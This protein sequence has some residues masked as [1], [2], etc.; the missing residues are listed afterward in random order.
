[1]ANRYEL[2]L[3]QRPAVYDLGL[4]GKRTHVFELAL[5]GGKSVRS[6]VF[7][8][9]IPF[10]ESFEVN[11]GVLIAGGV[12]SL[13]ALKTITAGASIELVEQVGDFLKI[14][15]VT[16]DAG[17]EIGAH[18][19]ASLQKTAPIMDAGVVAAVEKLRGLAVSMTG[20][21]GEILISAAELLVVSESLF[22]ADESAICFQVSR[23]GSSAEKYLS[24]ELAVMPSASGR[25]SA[26]KRAS[27]DESS[28][29]IRAAAALTAGRY[30]LLS[31]MD[32]EQISG[33]DTMVLADVDFIADA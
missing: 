15:F 3:R 32:G 12:D 22:V 26:E 31:D 6:D 9:S 4:S 24:A 13:A 11:D 20:A 10:R 2:Y 8:D 27:P 14:T 18:A 30:R 7:I 17:M 33:F 21:E 29:C 25:S 1:M 5:E 19:G 16:M 23:P 28:V